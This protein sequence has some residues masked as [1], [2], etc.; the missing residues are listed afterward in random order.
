MERLGLAVALIVAAIAVAAVL[1]RRGGDA[2]TQ[3][4]WS[5]PSQLDPADLGHLHATWAVVTFTSATCNSCA[6]VRS[7]V[8]G[9]AD[10]GRVAVIDLEVG[11]A[12]ELHERYGID[13]VPTLVLVDAA[14]GVVHA[15]AVGPLDPD[16][17][18]RLAELCAA[19]PPTLDAGTPVDLP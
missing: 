8:A 16:D 15:S 7:D 14:T 18:N 10:P 9:L 19:Q 12:R 13:A 3:T 1:R 5:V 2:P 6:A 4:S 11:E 17:R